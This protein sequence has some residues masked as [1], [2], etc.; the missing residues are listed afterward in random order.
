MIYAIGILALILLALVIC[1]NILFK[2]KDAA[3]VK[4]DQIL[5]DKQKTLESDIN[6]LKNP[7]VPNTLTPEEVEAFW[8]KN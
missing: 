3:L 7:I 1:K 6:K 2:A 4:E 8:K 5:Q